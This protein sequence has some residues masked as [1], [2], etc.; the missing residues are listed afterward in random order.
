MKAISISLLAVAL[1]P[2][3]YADPVAM[4]I[5]DDAGSGRDA[6]F[7]NRAEIWIEP[8]VMYA[9][10]LGAPTPDRVDIGDS[11]AFRATEGDALYVAVRGL[12]TLHGVGDAEGNL[13]TADVSVATM[14]IAG[15]ELTVPATG[16]YFLQV[17]GAASPYCFAYTL[18]A[19][20]PLG[21]LGATPPECY[22][23]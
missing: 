2:V 5:A 23:E 16:T 10:A 12:H 14:E 6:P 19:S 9:G 11:Y 1:L 8:G 17:R 21:A 3:A 22:L 7:G 20:W 15:T 18:D 4:V 13:L